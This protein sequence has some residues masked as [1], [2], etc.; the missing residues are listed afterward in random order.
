M[1]EPPNI[2]T[3]SEDELHALVD[4][5]LPA[6]RIPAVMHWL[7]DHPDD[8]VRVAHW[9]AQRLQLREHHRTLDIGDT[10]DAMR[11]VVESGA[12]Y[13][14]AGSSRPW[15]QAMAATV[16]LAVGVLGGHLATNLWGAR[17]PSNA[18][19]LAGAPSSPSPPEALAVARMGVF[20]RDAV[21]AHAV[22][23]PEVRHPVEVGA[24]N[25]AHLVQWLSRRL[26]APLKVPSLQS[27]GYRLLGGRL[28]ATTE[29]PRAQFMYERLDAQG[30]SKAGSRI[31]LYVTVLDAE[32]KDGTTAAFRSAREGTLESFYWIE[33]RFGYALTGTLSSNDAMA[34]AREVY[35]QLRPS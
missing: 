13:A 26:G 1:V 21:A 35:R 15:L 25:E 3:V 17:V 24:D 6:A 29:G 23:A 20:G 19:S 30:P 18:G 27:Q 5:Q 14:A 9:Q 16:V 7:R 10:P 12:R 32:P 33:G 28:L 4:G 11:R 8:A 31:T 34:L 2:Q 22:F